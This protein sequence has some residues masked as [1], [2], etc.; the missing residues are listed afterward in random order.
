MQCS[1]LTIYVCNVYITTLYAVNLYKTQGEPAQQCHV[2]LDPFPYSCYRGWWCFI[3]LFPFSVFTSLKSRCWD[4]LSGSGC[5]GRMEPAR[6]WGRGSLWFHD[7]L[8]KL[9]QASVAQFPLEARKSIL[10]GQFGKKKKS[11][12]TLMDMRHL[13]VNLRFLPFN[14]IKWRRAAISVDAH[15]W[16]A[17]C[18]RSNYFSWKADASNTKAK[19]LALHID[20]LG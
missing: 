1:Q 5:K 6:V 19:S 3:W 15:E 4:M 10:Q 20:I 16:F 18:C 9:Q 12:T 17:W 11:V 14:S 8:I 2:T 13:H 7:Q